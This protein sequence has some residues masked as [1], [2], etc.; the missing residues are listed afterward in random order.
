MEHV[1][2]RI[3]YLTALKEEVQ[4]NEIICNKIQKIISLCEE[5]LETVIENNN[6]MVQ[7]KI[8]LIIG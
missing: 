6:K 5:D 2:E 4:I 1:K 3:D 7:A 8:T